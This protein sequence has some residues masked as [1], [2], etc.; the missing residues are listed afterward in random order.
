MQNTCTCF[1]HNYWIYLLNEVLPVYVW[2]YIWRINPTI[3]LTNKRIIQN[4]LN[5]TNIITHAKFQ[6]TIQ[7]FNTYRKR[8]HP[9]SALPFIAK[10]IY[11]DSFSLCVEEEI[12]PIN[13]RLLP[14]D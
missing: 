13:C 4:I 6:I 7:N 3:Q 11:Y 10:L 14:H 5:L 8:I 9:D 12:L 1:A 2:I